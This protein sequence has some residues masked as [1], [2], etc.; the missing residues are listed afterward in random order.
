[1]LEARYKSIV[2]RG[3]SICFPVLLYVVFLLDRMYK[4]LKIYLPLAFFGLMHD[5]F[6][7]GLFRLEVYTVSLVIFSRFVIPDMYVIA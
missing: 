3:F 4:L 7:L 2:K 5:V 1:M 6:D